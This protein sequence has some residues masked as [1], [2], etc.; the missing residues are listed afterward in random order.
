MPQVKK[1]N[2]ILRDYLSIAL[3]LGYHDYQHM[4]RDFR[5]FTSLTPNQFAQH[6]SQ[7]PER[8]FGLVET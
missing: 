5:E 1:C 6:E 7:A 2:L 8:T 4:V 3:E